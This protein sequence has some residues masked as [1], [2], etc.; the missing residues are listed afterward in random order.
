MWKGAGCCWWGWSTAELGDAARQTPRVGG[1]RSD[2]GHG[3]YVKQLKM[4]AQ[5]NYMQLLNWDYLPVATLFKQP[6][7]VLWKFK[8]IVAGVLCQQNSV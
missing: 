8:C 3:F 5:S 2:S 4:V 7:R 6:R 1:T